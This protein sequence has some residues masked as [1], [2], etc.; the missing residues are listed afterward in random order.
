MTMKEK[1]EQKTKAMKIILSLAKGSWK[2]KKKILVMI[3]TLHAA[4]F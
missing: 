1:N 2:S 3:S 4:F